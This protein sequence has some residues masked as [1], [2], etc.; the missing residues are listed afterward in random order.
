MWEARE[1]APCIIHTSGFG[2]VNHL[3]QVEAGKGWGC[4]GQVLSMV[5]PSSLIKCVLFSKY[6]LLWG[7]IHAPPGSVQS[8]AIPGMQRPSLDQCR[9]WGGLHEA[10]WEMLASFQKW[11]AATVTFFL[12]SLLTPLASS[13]VASWIPA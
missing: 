4:G 11:Q 3:L 9:V 1:L 5:F 2:L 7:G 13:K 8:P 12:L 10:G 6:C